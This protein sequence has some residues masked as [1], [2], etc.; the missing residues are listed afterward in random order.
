M[1]RALRWKLIAG[2]L[3]V[4]LAGGITGALV[5]GSYTRQQYSRSPHRPFLKH[6][7]GERL[8]VELQLTAEQVANI[9][10]IIDKATDELE[11]IR[12]ET[13]RR[14]HQTMKEAHREMGAS[15]TEEQRAKLEK[16]EFRHHRRKMR[17]FHEREQPPAED[18]QQ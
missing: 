15:L 10:P 18:R 1:N 6:R 7:M 4:F 3:L 14:V 11:T 9:S 13:G 17:R 8:R 12:R 16:M 5:G 2:F